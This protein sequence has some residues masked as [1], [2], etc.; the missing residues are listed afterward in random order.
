[1]SDSDLPDALC[2][3]CGEPL[4]MTDISVENFEATGRLI[5]DECAAELFED[6]G[7]DDEP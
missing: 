2:E 3:D 4:D 1:M 5:C 7:E 6:S